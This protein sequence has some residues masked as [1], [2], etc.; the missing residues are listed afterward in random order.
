MNL[1]VGHQAL[2]INYLLPACLSFPG[3]HGEE[4]VMGQ[5]SKREW[6]HGCNRE[7]ETVFGTET[8]W[9]CRDSGMYWLSIPTGCC[10]LPNMDAGSQTWVLYKC[11]TQYPPPRH[12][13]SSWSLKYGK[14]PYKNMCYCKI[15]SDHSDEITK[16]KKAIIKTTT[17][18]KT[19]QCV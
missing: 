14:F 10:K 18:T 11:D 2:F 4:I 16:Q 19:E 5:L 12:L 9:C 6:P 8:T 3:S 15:D 17:T 1:L 13:S 7:T